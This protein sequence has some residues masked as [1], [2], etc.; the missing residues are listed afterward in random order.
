MPKS[1]MP[2]PMQSALNAIDV[3][4]DIELIMAPLRPTAEMI[5]IG[6][7]VANLSPMQAQLVYE[8]M[9]RASIPDYP[10]SD[11]LFGL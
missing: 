11:L 10:I 5:E 3:L 1:N 8:A 9:I 2:N 4:K 6:C 7:K